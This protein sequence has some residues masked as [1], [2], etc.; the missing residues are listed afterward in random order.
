M[1][2]RFLSILAIVAIVLGIANSLTWVWQG[3]GAARL[4]APSIPQL[5]SYQGRLT[6]AAGNPLTGDYDMRLCLYDV[7]SGGSALWCEDQTVSVTH[8]VFSVL[9]GSSTSIP[10]ALFDGPGLYLGVKVGSDDE[11]TPRGRVVSVGYAYRADEASTA[12]YASSAGNADTVD[13]RHASDFASASHR[14][15]SLDADDGDPQ[16]A[17][18]VDDAGNVVIGTAASGQSLTVA[19]IVE[20]INGGFKFP[21]GSVQTIAASKMTV[22]EVEAANEVQINT[23][24]WQDLPNMS[25]TLTTNG[26]ESLLIMAKAYIYA[27]LQPGC[28]SSGWLRLL[29]DTTELDKGAEG[30]F[31]AQAKG[32]SGMVTLVDSRTPSAGSHTYKLQWGGDG[33]IYAS[34]RRITILRIG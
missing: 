1:N 8:G 5:I 26:T 6:D 19:G 18:F 2:K 11:M 28:G 3:A 12:D 24:D 23:S 15:N 21:D 22:E 29:E 9:L 32:F 16:N 30:R 34:W 4:S 7:P 25:I 10:Q 20:A 27:P 13:D 33:A 31:E 14:H 17:L